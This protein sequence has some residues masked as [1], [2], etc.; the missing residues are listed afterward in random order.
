[1]EKLRLKQKWLNHIL[2]IN[3][4]LKKYLT[5]AKRK[6][7]AEEETKRTTQAKCHPWD[8]TNARQKQRR[9]T[10]DILIIVNLEIPGCGLL[11]GYPP[12]CRIAWVPIVT[13]THECTT[14]LT[15]TNSPRSTKLFKQFNH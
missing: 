5:V 6:R 15:K 14:R 4:Y 13:V 8:L 10:N 11:R 7:Q 2:V 9:M 3:Y 12:V 1:M